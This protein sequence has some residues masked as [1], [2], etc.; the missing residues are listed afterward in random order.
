MRSWERTLVLQIYREKI[1]FPHNVFY[2]HPTHA[3]AST[4]RIDARII[5]LLGSALMGV[6]TVAFG[7]FAAG[8]WSATLLWGLAGIGCAGA[9]MPGLRAL[10]D[11]LGDGG[12]AG[13]GRLM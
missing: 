11:R 3:D 7:L 6:A 1:E 10:T 4:D 8:L 9:Y 5:L 13:G 12:G 2:P